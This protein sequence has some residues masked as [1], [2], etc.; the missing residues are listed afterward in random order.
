MYIYVPPPPPPTFTRPETCW[1]KHIDLSVILL[2]YFLCM[3]LTVVI[4]S[5]IDLNCRFLPLNT[6][7][8]TLTQKPS[9]TVHQYP[10]L[11]LLSYFVLF[12]YY[13]IIFL[14][15]ELST[16]P[17]NI[18]SIVQN[19]NVIVKMGH[20]GIA[21]TTLGVC[22]RLTVL[23][24]TNKA[25]FCNYPFETIAVWIILMRLALCPDIH[26]NPGP[27]H[28]HNFAG[29][30]LSFCNWNLNTLSKEDFVR[31]TL[32]EAHNTVHNYDIISLCETSLDDN[33]QVPEMPGYKFHSCNHPDG[34]RSGGVGIF[35]KESLPLKIREDLSFNESIV[36]ELIFGHKHIFSQFYIETHRIKQILMNL[37][38]SLKI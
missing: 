9:K 11:L 19:L 33:V 6:R 31:I 32:L 23:S 22:H 25:C 21:N 7:L 38:H 2:P 8:N 10:L 29:G 14:P 20:C 12:E 17:L 13:F 30:F 4:F 27:S 15:Y 37:I 34:N 16:V 35:Y 24:F 3:C 36:C 28:L 5:N 18:K 1:S 26:P